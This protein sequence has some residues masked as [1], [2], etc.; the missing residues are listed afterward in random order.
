M[1][2][3]PWV[4]SA[5]IAYLAFFALPAALAAQAGGAT[6]TLEKLWESRLDPAAVIVD[7]SVGADGSMRLLVSFRGSVYLQE[8]GPDGAPRGL[9]EVASAGGELDL[10]EPLSLRPAGDYLDVYVRGRA[11]LSEVV[12]VFR[13]GGGLV[14]EVSSVEL[15]EGY[16]AYD[17]V[18]TQG[19]LL[20]AGSAYVYPEGWKPFMALYTLFGTPLWSVTL[21]R[22]GSF[23]QVEVLG[24]AACGIYEASENVVGVACFSL[25][26]GSEL[27]SVEAEG[28]A[29]P[30]GSLAAAG[31][32]CLVAALGG[33]VAV[34]GPGGE[35]WTLKAI[36]GIVASVDL[37]PQGLVVAVAGGGESP[38]PGLVL[39]AIPLGGGCTPLDPVAVGSVYRSWGGGPVLADYSEGYLGLAVAAGG[40]WLAGVYL[41]ELGPAEPVDS[42]EGQDAG[43]RGVMGLLQSPLL[44]AA[45]L[46]ALA[47]MAG[48][49]V[50]LRL[51][52]GRSGLRG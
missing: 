27:G 36:G 15:G 6:L 35:G 48:I 25:A 38:E 9:I 34:G 4:L 3:R 46:V 21:D 50:S 28:E 17:A 49:A 20:V 12:A 10:V 33:N 39:Y 11:G 44:T 24:D 51:L 13:V 5:L 8:V 16:L 42:G 18:L 26:E 7:I 1:R 22:E 32:R 14:E 30:A 19:G 43:G 47:F 37:G 29:P 2:G 31:G 40:G 23:L 41:V 52:G 45:L